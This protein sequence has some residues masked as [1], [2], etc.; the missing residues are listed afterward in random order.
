MTVEFTRRAVSD[1]TRIADE[2]RKRFGKSVAAELQFRFAQI[3][4]RL[5]QAPMSA[6]AANGKVGIRVAPL[7]RYP[8]RIYY[9]ALADRIVVQHI[10]HTS[11]QPW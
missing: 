5:E 7:G 1:L 11:R 10:R 3:I 4:A 6:Q 8:F 2:S 9:L